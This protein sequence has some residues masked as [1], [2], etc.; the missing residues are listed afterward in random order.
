MTAFYKTW[1][2]AKPMLDNGLLCFLTY[3]DIFAESDISA[4]DVTIALAK[5]SW[6]GITS[7]FTRRRGIA[8]DA[9]TCAGPMRAPR[10]ETWLVSMVGMPTS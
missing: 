6:S 9:S 7:H 3:D 8:A 2:S 4:L 1:L 10:T 5:L